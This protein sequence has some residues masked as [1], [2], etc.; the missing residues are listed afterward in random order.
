MGSFANT[1]FSL[2]LGWLKTVTSTIWSALTN[3]GNESFLQFIGKNWILIAVILCAAGLAVDFAVYMFRW[4]PWKVWRSFWRRIKHRDTEPEEEIP[5]EEDVYA[6]P[7][8]DGYEEEEE[9][10]APEPEPTEEEAFARWREER[11]VR[12]EPRAAAEVTRAGYEVPYDSVYR[13]PV[14]REAPAGE[15]GTGAPTRRRR[16]FS[17]LL[18][19]ADDGEQFHYF[20]PRP[21]MDHRDAYNEPVYPQKWKTNR[22]GENEQEQQDS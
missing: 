9:Q 12:E 7:Y 4:E 5:P 6:D 10:Q 21:I 2:L 17:N 22:T 19:E 11:P 15:Y 14:D 20:A 3:K 16:R 1:L 18:G 13:R 8:R